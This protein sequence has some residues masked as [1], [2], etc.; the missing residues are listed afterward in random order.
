MKKGFV[1]WIHLTEQNDPHTQGYVG[2]T[3][4]IKRRMREHTNRKE[5]P[6]LENVFIKYQNIVVDIL[7]VGVYDYCYEVER[8]YRPFREIGW[9]ISEGGIKP[10]NLKG[11]KKSLDTRMKMSTNNV[12][13][14]DK[15]HSFE[16]KLKMSETRKKIGGRPHTEETKKKLS[17]IAKL[18]KFNPMLGKKH[19]EKTKQLMSQKKRHKKH[20]SHTGEKYESISIAT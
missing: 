15:K 8:E 10:P 19:S 13:F 9:N 2:V 12:G 6:I 4:D 5:N 3:N 18:R 11:T 7:F 14:K 20:T 16:T 17:E 1:Y